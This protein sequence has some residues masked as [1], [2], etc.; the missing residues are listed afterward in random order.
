MLTFA[1]DHWPEILQKIASKTGVCRMR[2]MLT[3]C[4]SLDGTWYCSKKGR[5]FFKHTMQNL[6]LWNAHWRLHWRHIAGYTQEH[7]EEFD[8]KLSVNF[9]SRQSVLLVCV[10]CV[11]VCVLSPSASE[12]AAEQHEENVYTVDP[13]SVDSQIQFPMW[14]HGHFEEK[15]GCDKRGSVCCE[16]SQIDR[17]LPEQRPI[18]DGRNQ[19]FIPQRQIEPIQPWKPWKPSTRTQTPVFALTA[20]EHGEKW[21]FAQKKVLSI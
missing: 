20:Q 8:G 1:V 15:A 17:L 14:S 4:S 2:E 21:H 11:C 18:L 10:V 3:S 6:A 7:S 9:L 12:F 5:Q 13:A 16:G 19:R